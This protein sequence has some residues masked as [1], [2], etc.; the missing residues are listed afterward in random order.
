MFPAAGDHEI[1]EC[2]G[3]SPARQQSGPGKSPGK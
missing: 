2:L 1:R 3:L